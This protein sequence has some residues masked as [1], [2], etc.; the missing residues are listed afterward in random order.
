MP[1]AFL[2]ASNAFFAAFVAAETRLPIA[3]PMPEIMPRIMLPPMLDHCTCV[4]AFLKLVQ[5]CAASCIRRDGILSRE[6]TSAFKIDVP[7]EPIAPIAAR[8]APSSPLIALEPRLNR[9]P[10]SCATAELI[11][12]KTLVPADAALATMPRTPETRLEI[13]L[14]PRFSSA[15]GSSA[16]LSRTVL[17]MFCAAFDTKLTAPE[18]PLPS[19]S[20]MFFPRLIQLNA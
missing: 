4:K 10:G 8:I 13:A 20:M 14:L 11:T 6:L 2:A 7:A 9:A 17:K 18:I 12:E 1:S 3:E 19:K 16:I 15:E 5:A